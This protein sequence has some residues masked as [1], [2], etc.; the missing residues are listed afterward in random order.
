MDRFNALLERLDCMVP[1]LAFAVGAT[2]VM[3]YQ[4]VFGNRF[5]WEPTIRHLSDEDGGLAAV[6]LVASAAR[7]MLD[8][9]C[10]C[11]DSLPGTSI[12]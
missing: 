12:E 3:M 1:K 6:V 11:D 8:P 4:E 5:E 9:Q 2:G 7:T 10:S